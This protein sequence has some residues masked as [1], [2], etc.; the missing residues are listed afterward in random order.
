MRHNVQIFCAGLLAVAL[1][2]GC[3]TG[4]AVRAADTAAGAGDWDTAAAYYRQA[5]N[6][7][8][9]RLDVRTKLERATRLA[10]AEHVTRARQLEAQDQIP[11]AIAEYRLAADLDPSN[12][13][14]LQKA[15]ELERLL[16]QQIEASRPRP[17]LAALREQGAQQ[18]TIPRLPPNTIVPEMRFPR[19]SVLDILTTLGNLTGINIT[20]DALLE[21][22]LSRPFSIDVK[23]VPLEDVLNQILQAN[24]LA[25]TV[26][27]PRTIF[28]YQDTP[29]NRQ[30]YEELYVQQFFISNVEPNAILGQLNAVFG[31]GQTTTS[32][33]P[34]FSLNEA[35][36]IINV[37]ATAPMLQVIDAFIAAND[38]A[39]PEVLI[40]AEILEVDRAFLRQIGLDLS[41]F[42]FGFT[43]SPEVS[44]SLDPGTFPPVTPPPFNLNTLRGG[45]SPA[46]FYVTT[47]TALVHLLES[48]SNTRTLAKPSQRGT[49]GTKIILT[50][51]QSVPIPTTT[52]Q[53][54]L[55]GPATIP[56]TAVDYQP[57]GVNLALTPT[58]TYDNEIILSDLTLEKSGLGPNLDI[59][60]QNFPTITSR[61][62]TIS[63]TRLRDGE[64]TL[65]AGLLLDEERRVGRSLPGVSSVPLLRNLFGNTENRIEETDIVMIITPRIVRGHGLTADDVR[66]TYVGTGQ[67]I[68]PSPSPPLL[69]PEGLGLTP[70]PAAPPASAPAPAPTVPPAAAAPI[71]PVTPAQGTPA[72]GNGTN[73]QTRVI[74]SPPSTGPTG[75]L[76]AGGGPYTMPIQIAGASDLSTLSLT[77][78]YDPSVVTQATAT[79]GSFMAQGGV[80]STFVPGIDGASGRIDLAF[81]R[82]GAGIGATGSGLLAAIAFT[83]GEAGSTEIRVTGVGT[84]SK[85]ETVPLQFTP[86]RVTV[87]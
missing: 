33:R 52:F 57:V 29:Q 6:E 30:K 4:R 50:M 23:D 32:V 36:R 53:S 54:Q 8:P 44:P 10:S 28:V 18:S 71:V 86:A 75:A 56:T 48:N 11:G 84:T 79:P 38:R 61:K 45:I 3:A 21:G 20:Y 67:N 82:P 77:I 78:T 25:Y 70:T 73:G 39:Q 12:V 7:S 35:A 17:P 69:T 47:P 46:D 34:I 85:G 63:A 60:G 5:L 64:S 87:R 26:R 59:G 19:A 83:A 62:A 76:L 37:R 14:A 58:V 16:R 80:A 2:S 55:G 51:G 66:P 41:R 49:S 22:N 31:A 72:N 1:V 15:G 9:D 65:V 24:Q 27:N 40:E 81:S 13:H 68:A 43:F 74:L 42:A